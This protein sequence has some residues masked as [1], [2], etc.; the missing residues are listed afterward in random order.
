MSLFEQLK[1]YLA[2]YQLCALATVI[3]S[4]TGAG[5]KLLILPDGSAQGEMVE[6]LRSEVIA[7][8]QAQMRSETSETIDVGDAKVYQAQRG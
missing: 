7:R 2:V 3:Q 1:Q 8:A 4:P 6:P 5:A